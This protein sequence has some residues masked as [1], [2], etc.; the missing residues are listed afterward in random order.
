MININHTKQMTK[1]KK[2]I[3]N[4][5][6]MVLYLLRNENNKN[7]SF[8]QATDLNNILDDIQS[9]E[10]ISTI[11]NKCLKASI[12]SIKKFKTSEPFNDNSN[13]KILIQYLRNKHND[14]VGC[15][16]ATNI[17]KKCYGEECY[18]IGASSCSTKYDRYDK[19]FGLELAKKR[20]IESNHSY[21]IRWEHTGE[22][23]KFI[24]RCDTYYKNLNHHSDIHID[25]NNGITLISY[26]T[27]NN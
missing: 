7:L 12:L 4:L 21:K 6:Q 26:K 5:S 19:R 16:Y 1:Y 23:I 22:F 3:E 15:L 18:G 10:I 17:S 13:E 8:R 24:R 27:K 14:I 25:H 9:P 11:D 2:V 20:A